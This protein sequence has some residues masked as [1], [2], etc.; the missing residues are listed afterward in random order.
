MFNKLSYIR[1]KKQCFCW[2]FWLANN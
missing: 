1:T 2:Y